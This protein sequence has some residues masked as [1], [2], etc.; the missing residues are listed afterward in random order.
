MV[1][2]ADHEYI[3][4]L[5]CKKCIKTH[6]YT[7]QYLLNKSRLRYVWYTVILAYNIPCVLST[8]F[9]QPSR[10]WSKLCFIYS[11][12]PTQPFL[13]QTVCYPLPSPNPAVPGPNCVLSTPFSKPSRTWSKLCFI[14]SL[15]PIQPY[16]VQTVFYL[17][18]SPNPAVPGT[19]WRFVYLLWFKKNA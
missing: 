11:R 9:S 10:T 8:P 6:Q 4:E 18:P 1:K 7:Y 13:V 19:I 2:L 14:Y 3:T 12:L 17:L 15:L 16:L 5:K